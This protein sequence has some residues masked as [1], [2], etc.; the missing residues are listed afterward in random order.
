MRYNKSTH[1]NIINVEYKHGT[2]HEWYGVSKKKSFFSTFFPKSKPYT[3]NEN[4]MEKKCD[5][6]ISY[7]HKYMHKPPVRFFGYFDR[8]ISFLENDSINI[9]CNA[10]V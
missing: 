1:Y 2:T 10:I 6:E 7:H 3:I 4:E 9:V 5:K 8:F